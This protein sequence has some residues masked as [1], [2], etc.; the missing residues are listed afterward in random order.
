[1]S[2]IIKVSYLVMT[3]CELPNQARIFT[4][5]NGDNRVYA[6]FSEARAKANLIN[7]KAGKSTARVVAL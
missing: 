4:E 3:G 2:E 5:A 7:Q 1:M 6:N